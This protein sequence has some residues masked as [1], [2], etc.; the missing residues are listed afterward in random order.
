M[1]SQFYLELSRFELRHREISGFTICL[2]Y[3]VNKL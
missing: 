1:D 3:T 2:S